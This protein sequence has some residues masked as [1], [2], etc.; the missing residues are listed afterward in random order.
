MAV[1]MIPGGVENA[2]NANLYIEGL[3]EV[4]PPITAR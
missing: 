1:T 3:G 2:L 4:P